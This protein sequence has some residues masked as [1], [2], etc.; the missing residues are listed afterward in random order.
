VDVKGSYNA[1]KE[2]L[3]VFKSFSIKFQEESI[4][5]RV[6]RN[7]SAG[8]WWMSSFGQV[9]GE[10]WCEYSDVVTESV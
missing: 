6:T 5:T 3:R 8:K 2:F 9:I 1:N 10:F 4:C 7:R